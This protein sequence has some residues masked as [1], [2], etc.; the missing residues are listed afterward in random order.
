MTPN[1][2]AQKLL[3]NVT[4]F[5]PIINHKRTCSLDEAPRNQGFRSLTV[6]D[7]LP[8]QDRS[9]FIKA[10]H[11]DEIEVETPIQNITRFFAKTTQNQANESQVNVNLRIC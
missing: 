10:A 8:K 1:L 7:I 3:H 2:T 9:T 11:Q 6:F 5:C 4:L